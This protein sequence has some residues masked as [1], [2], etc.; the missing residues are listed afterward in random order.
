MKIDFLASYKDIAR[1][2]ETPFKKT[3]GVVAAQTDFG[4]LLADIAPAINKEKRAELGGY[5]TE[6]GPIQKRKATL[7]PGP[8]ARFKFP[9]APVEGPKI[10]RLGRQ[11]TNTK[12]VNET[13]RSVK[14]PASPDP[15]GLKIRIPV[16]TKA[17]EGKPE[18]GRAKLLKII[19]RAGIKHGVDPVLGQAIAAVE[20][21]FNAQAVSQ[22]GHNSKGLF[23]LLDS[24]GRELLDQSESS[25]EYDPFNPEMNVD[26]GVKYLRRLHDLFS[27]D[28]VL[29]NNFSTKAAANSSSLEKLAVAAFNAGEGRV[30]AAQSRA[31]KDGKDPALY[32][33]IE[34][35]L[36]DSTREY[37]K[38]ILAEKS[39]FE[40][41]AIG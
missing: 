8:M 34:T 19:D 13:A 20:S 25:A 31:A 30:A 17:A 35:Y 29:P 10:E 41:S 15:A 24:T 7:E 14:T 5:N 39:R 27:R 16:E 36:P 37:V 4:R 2:L 12:F 40:N 3:T 9:E 1:A 11:E 23:Q 33:E 38:R 22:D 21:G 26:L 6:A 18:D 28:S 32:E